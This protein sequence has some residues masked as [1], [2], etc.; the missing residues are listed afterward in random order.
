[1]NTLSQNNTLLENVLQ[2]LDFYSKYPH[3]RLFSGKKVYELH[4]DVRYLLN[5][6]FENVEDKQKLHGN[7]LWK[8]KKFYSTPFRK[9][10]IALVNANAK[11]LELNDNDKLNY[12]NYILSL[13]GSQDFSQDVFNNFAQI[14]YKDVE[15]QSKAIK[16]FK[17]M[18][19]LL[20]KTPKDSVKYENKVRSYYPFIFNLAKNSKNV[21]QQ[22]VRDVADTL[23][24]VSKNLKYREVS[25]APLMFL[26]Q[27]T[28]AL[29]IQN[30]KHLFADELP[31]ETKPLIDKKAVENIM[32]DYR[33]FSLKHD[34]K[35][36]ADMNLYHAITSFACTVVEKFDYTPKD[37]KSLRQKLGDKHLSGITNSRLYEMGRLIQRAYNRSHP[38]GMTSRHKTVQPIYK[39]GY[40]RWD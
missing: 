29:S 3:M 36:L 32:A 26:V 24:V 38:Q 21:S 28:A 19:I 11:I 2:K 18:K 14:S 12:L 4:E 17:K 6:P 25:M 5:K 9:E 40:S 22:F 8:I 39:A 33:N 30:V 10:T 27:N 23:F 15:T 35:G 1:M 13:N 16:V 37:V 7:F 31:V 34:N 20:G